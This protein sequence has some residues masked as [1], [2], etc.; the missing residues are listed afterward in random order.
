MVSLKY[1]QDINP[2]DMQL[3]L[4]IQL[5]TFILNET[6]KNILGKTAQKS[7]NKYKVESAYI[8]RR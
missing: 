5:A 3:I 1:L 2:N 8:V 6:G 7:P 4:N